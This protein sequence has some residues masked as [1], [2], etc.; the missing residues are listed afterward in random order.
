MLEKVSVRP[1][2]RFTICCFA[3]LLAL[4]LALPHPSPAKT[5]VDFDPSADFSKF[6]TFA[7]I[8]GVGN[9]V[10]LQIDPDVM[11]TRIHQNVVREL[12]KKGLREVA[13]AENPDV[14]VRFWVSPESQVNVESMGSWAPYSSYLSGSWGNVYNAVISSNTRVNNLIIDMIAVKTKSLAWRLY[15]SKKL[16]DPEKDWKRIDDEF[17]DGFKNYPPSDKEKA[18]KSKERASQKPS[19]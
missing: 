13:A 10:M 4:L 12:T 16:S 14:V 17:T 3:F 19:S 1:E 9:L 7:F 15:V 18:D 11:Y 8:G 5:T 6:K 2:P